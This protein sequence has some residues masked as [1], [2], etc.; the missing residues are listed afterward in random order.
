MRSSTHGSRQHA[1]IDSMTKSILTIGW[2]PASW[3]GVGMRDWP[4]F[5]RSRSSS[6]NTTQDR[7]IALGVEDRERL[8]ALG[9]DLS[10]AWD[11]AG[12]SIETRKKIVRLV[13][14]EIIVDVVSRQP[15]AGHP[16]A[17]W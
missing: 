7:L 3:N 6:L 14:A 9:R 4:A 8:L 12:A 17:W 11:G 16:L 2:S 5:I 1:R 10:R 15:R 13:I